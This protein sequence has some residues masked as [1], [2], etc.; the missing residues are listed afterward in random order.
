MISTPARSLAVLLGL[1]LGLAACRRSESPQQPPIPQSSS[2]HSSARPAL[3]LSPLSLPR[4]VR[5]A[6]VESGPGVPAM[7]AMPVAGADRAFLAEAASNGLAEVAA[8]RLVASRTGDQNIRALA[9]QLERD[10]VSANA[11]L[12]RVAAQKGL[13]LPAAPAGEPAQMLA[14]LGKL[15]GRE[16]N[17]AFIEDFGIRAHQLAI[18]LFERQAREG[19]DPDL[20]ALAERT[21]PRLREHLAMARQMQGRPAAG[22]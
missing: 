12:Q 5:V 17:R 15:S 10:H 8:S 6:A 4:V 14:R 1:A 18:G 16:L 11:E 22:P 21:L 9:Q 20:K 2:V 7:P 13:A 19:Q 3:Q